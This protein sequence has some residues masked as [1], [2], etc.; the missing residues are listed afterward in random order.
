M[1]PTQTLAKRSFDLFGSFAGLLILWP[2]ILIG[3]GVAALDTGANGFFAQVRVGQ[4]GEMFKVVK[5]RTMRVAAGTSVTTIHDTRITRTGRFMRRWKIDELPQ[6]WNVFRGQMSLVGPR[7]DVPGFMDKLTGDD[8]RLLTLKPGITGPASLRFRDEEMQL[9]AHA[10]PETYNAQVIWPEKV[11]IN[12]AYMD[13]WSLM[14]DIHYI[15]RTVL[16]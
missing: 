12:L 10:N 14:R 13:N 7:P 2:V 3:A 15:I 1:T 9:A 4:H 6:L 8:R 11:K 5:L 16:G